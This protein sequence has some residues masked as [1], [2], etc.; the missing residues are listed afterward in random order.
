[1]FYNCLEFNFCD[2]CTIVNWKGLDYLDSLCLACYASYVYIQ[3]SNVSG[4]QKKIISDWLMQNSLSNMQLTP[5][6]L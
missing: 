1:M 4:V 2:I 3:L 5:T 6:L